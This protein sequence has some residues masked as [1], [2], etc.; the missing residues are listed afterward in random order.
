MKGIRRREL[1]IDIPAERPPHAGPYRNK[2]SNGEVGRL[3][4]IPIGMTLE[5]GLRAVGGFTDE[6]LAEPSMRREV[7]IPTFLTYVH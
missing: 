5:D 2:P 6:E 3:I 4:G 7:G 1:V